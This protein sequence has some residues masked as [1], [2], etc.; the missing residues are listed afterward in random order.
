MI[1]LLVAGFI[2][3]HMSVFWVWYRIAH[4]PSVVD[5]GW[6]S[7]LTFSGLIYL[8]SQ[9]ISLRSIILSLILILW[10]MRLGFYLWFTRIRHG[11]VDKRYQS[12]SDDW[13]IAK[14]L[15]FFLNFHLQGVL[16][17]I[18]SL[19]WLFASKAATSTPDRLDWL[20]FTLALFSIAMETLADYQLHRFKKIHINQ[21]CN[22][23][24]WSLCRHPN[25]F[26]DWLTWCAFVLFAL[27]HPVG[28]LAIISPLTLY[29]IMTQ[30]TGPMTE[31]GSIK[32]KGELYLQYQKNTPMF[33]PKFLIPPF[34]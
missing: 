17:L 6:A 5:I 33:F 10:G 16:I 22:Q 32:S 4:N 24:L 25:Y 28:W 27:A 30:V 29:W 9:T 20:A 12:L 14:P 34:F 11:K 23:G 19:P 18:V 7:G 21:V 1:I 31:K 13:K 2:V 3:L 26:F 8:T 15:G